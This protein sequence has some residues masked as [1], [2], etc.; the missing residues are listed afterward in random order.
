MT[1]GAFNGQMIGSELPV[2]GVPLVIE[3]F[4]IQPFI[5]G[6]MSSPQ[7]QSA[8]VPIGFSDELMGNFT[9]FDDATVTCQ[10][11]TENRCTSLVSVRDKCGDGGC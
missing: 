5:D 11:Y 1:F 4:T 3:K 8:V 2:N 6:L 10:L 9:V 7:L